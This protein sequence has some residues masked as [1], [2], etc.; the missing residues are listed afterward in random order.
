MSSLFKRRRKE[1]NVS[2]GEGNFSLSIHVEKALPVVHVHP[3]HSP[4]NQIS[5][6]EVTSSALKE[7]QFIS[8]FS[9]L[10]LSPSLLQ[11]CEALGFRKPTPVQRVVIP[12]LLSNQSDHLLALA[13]TGSGK[14]AAF[15]LPILHHLSLDPYGIYALVLSPT[16]ELAKQIHEQVMALGTLSV[17]VRS[18]LVIGGMDMTHQACEL[19]H[20]KPHFCI[21]TP[22]RLAAILRGPNPPPLKNVRYVVLDEAD[23]ILMSKSGFERDVAE[24]LLHTTTMSTARSSNE[25]EVDKRIRRTNFQTLLFSATLTRSLES[26]EHLAGAGMGKL[27]L[28]KFIIQDNPQD[29]NCKTKESRV[30]RPHEDVAQEDGTT[31]VDNKTTNHDTMDSKDTVDVS[32][33]PSLPAGLRQEYIFMPSHVR[34]GYLVTTIRHLMVNGGRFGD[35][36]T[37]RKDSSGWNDVGSKLFND[38]EKE[39]KMAKARSAIIFVSTCE[40]TALISGVLTE[41]GVG[42]VALHSL[43]SQNRRLAALAKFKSQHVRVLVATD[44]ASRGLDIPTVDLVVNAELPRRPVDYV[45]RVGRTARAGRRGRAISLVGESDVAL[46]HAVEKITGRPLEK[47][48]DITDELALKLLGSVTKAVRLTKMKLDDI[49]FDELVKKMKERKVRDRKERLKAERAA[50]RLASKSS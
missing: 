11:A 25:Q 50:R 15:V 3:S 12:F 24:I 45:H 14:T 16:R 49:G 4:S 10:R 39:R 47:C 38:E 28:K 6:N 27:H 43:L 29:L 42:N 35:E 19:V 46:V 8:R 44:V 34:D 23:R 7:E 30:K 5:S 26:L 40:R 9:D 21:A 2:L 13:A 36:E 22:G 32:G 20:K 1:K 37:D 41:L 33:I 31:N 18:S 48:A 17:R